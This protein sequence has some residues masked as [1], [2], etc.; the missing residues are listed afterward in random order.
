[1]LLDARKAAT[2]AVHIQGGL[3]AAQVPEFAAL[4]AGEEGTIAVDLAFSKDDQER[5]VVH[6]KVEADVAVT[7]QRCLGPMLQHI[8]GNTRL[9]VVMTDQQAAALPR[10][11]DPLLVEGQMCNLHALV[12]EELILALPPFNYHKQ[13]E[14]SVSLA[15][16]ADPIEEPQQARTNPFEV[17]G[18]LKHD[19]EHQE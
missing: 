9:A 15:V 19:E 2:R 4:L 13:S 14:C 16:Y 18:R 6:L 1:M 12:E 7:C 8:S 5:Y 3:R 11:L 17:L 10:H